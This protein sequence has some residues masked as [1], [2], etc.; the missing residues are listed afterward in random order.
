MYKVVFLGM[1]TTVLS[2]PSWVYSCLF[3]DKA[4]YDSHCWYLYT[5]FLWRVCF[6]RHVHVHTEN[7]EQQAPSHEFVSPKF[8]QTLKKRIC[9]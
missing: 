5:K 9:F 4:P 3:P 1:H 2:W 8:I 7:N 6:I